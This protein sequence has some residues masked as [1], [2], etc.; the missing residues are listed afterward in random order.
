M[1]ILL[2]GLNYPPELIGVGKY[3]GEMAKWLSKQGHDIR[4]V[5]AYPY[6]PQWRID[7]GRRWRG[8]RREVTADGIAV[9]RCPLWVPLRQSGLRRI[10]HLLSFAATSAPVIVAAA[11]GWRPDVVVAIAPAL[12]TAPAAWVAARICGAKA[13]LHIQD[14]E[15]DAAFGVGLLE[16]DHLR[17]MATAAESAL[18]QSF[19][20]VSTLSPPMVGRLRDKGI[21]ADRIRMLPNWVAI[22]EIRPL[23]T[24]STLRRELALPQSA[25]VAL[26]AGNMNEKQGLEILTDA[27]HR[28]QDAPGIYLVFAGEGPAKRTIEAATSGLTNVR[29]VPLQPADRLND[30]LNLADIHLLPQRPSVADLVMP[31]KLLG[32]M[33]SG[34]PVIAG[35]F[36]GTAVAAAVAHCGLA[37]SPEGGAFAAAI[38]SLADDPVTRAS[39]GRAARDHAVLNWSRDAVLS[40]FERDLVELRNGS[41]GNKGT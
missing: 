26:Y 2:Y 21:A 1:K 15:I 9:Y 24:P 13:W 4:V 38:R 41:L 37:V 12:V 29:F 30:L 20:R 5:T 39:L 35:A 3:S 33:A 25:V 34:R 36:A 23:S 32:M 28:L 22:D 16:G 8:W 7:D 10:L 14:F 6:Y 19:D 18:L 11:L 40:E 17:R 27:A 31:S